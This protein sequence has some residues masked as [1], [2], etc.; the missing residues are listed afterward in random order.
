MIKKIKPRAAG[1]QRGKDPAKM[2][3]GT[4]GP[5]STRREEQGSLPPAAAEIDA[6]IRLAPRRRCAHDSVVLKAA[7]GLGL[8]GHCSQRR[9][10]LFPGTRRGVQQCEEYQ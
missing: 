10:C 3:S 6:A 1:K 5:G 4:S 8:C 7:R 9:H 2:F